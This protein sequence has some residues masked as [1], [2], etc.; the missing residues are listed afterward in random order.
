MQLE[1]ESFLSGIEDLPNSVL[2]HVFTLCLDDTLPSRRW[3]ARR[4]EGRTL[5]C[6]TGGHCRR[7]SLPP[8]DRPPRTIPLVCRL[9]RDA[10]YNEAHGLWRSCR[11]NLLAAARD[12]L[13]HLCTFLRRHAAQFELLAVARLPS[14]LAPHLP[15][16]LDSALEALGERQE[17][18]VDGGGGRVAGAGRLRVLDLPLEG[19][20]VGR[21]L[22][23]PPLPSLERLRVAGVA[24]SSQLLELAC[25]PGLRRL[26]VKKP[27]AA[28][29]GWLSQGGCG[30]SSSGLSGGGSCSLEHLCCSLSPQLFGAL[31]WAAFQ[32]LATL[33]LSTGQEALA[34]PGPLTALQRLRGLRVHAAYPSAPTLL[35]TALSELSALEALSLTH[36]RFEQ[37][38]SLALLPSLSAF[39]LAGSGCC[40]A[41]VLRAL[42]GACALRAL[43]LS[44]LDGLDEDALEALAALPGGLTRL[45]LPRCQL[46]Q[47]S[48]D[49]AALLA[50]L[51]VLNLADNWWAACCCPRAAFTPARWLAHVPCPAARKG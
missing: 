47:L 44:A 42:R 6:R 34:L 50:S 49:C 38:G 31:P 15:E 43:S 26:E 8:L 12:Q 11:L 1:E 19:Q 36:A 3:N 10:A 27:A 7:L 41:P 17:A 21:L 16:L 20:Q 4:C 51:R 5:R 33:S 24:D 32:A 22:S 18:G 37:P 29:P 28:Q 40:K 9:W 39:A 23:L 2:V 45:D 14:Q 48:A 25:L 30:L 35:G 13:P 46:R